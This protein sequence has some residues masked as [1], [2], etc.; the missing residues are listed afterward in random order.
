MV[1]KGALSSELDL[2]RASIAARFLRQQSQEYPDLVGLEE[3]LGKLIRSYESKHWSDLET[4]SQEQV[5]ENESAEK[6]A[7]A[8]FRFFRRRR[9]TILKKMKKA[10]IRQ[11]DLG[12]I[13]A[14]SKSYTSELLN[15][16]RPFSTTDLIVIH[17]LLEIPLDQLFCT[18]LSAST[19]EKVD[20]VKQNL[21]SADRKNKAS[22]S[23][24]LSSAPTHIS[25]SAADLK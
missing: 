12:F 22:Q 23:G 1:R 7:A 11:S 15:G 21:S 14:H 5:A 4:I 19:Q 9:D 18:E 3:E 20:L 2:H 10:G 13:L 24:S 25:M 8:E 17:Q 16:I 6:Q